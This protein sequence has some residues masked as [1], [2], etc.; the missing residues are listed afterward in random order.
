VKAIRTWR[1]RWRRTDR[2]HSSIDSS[3]KSPAPEALLE[4][5]H[6]EGHEQ[7]SPL[8]HRD[9]QDDAVVA[10]RHPLDVDVLEQPQVL[11]KE[12]FQTNMLKLWNVR[13]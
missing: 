6:R 3:R 2:G 7:R 8:L 1:C 10:V 4:A 9:A 5:A 11:D 13:G 12:P